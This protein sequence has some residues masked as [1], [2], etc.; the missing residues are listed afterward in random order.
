MGVRLLAAWHDSPNRFHHSESRAT[1]AQRHANESSRSS[2]EF[3][4]V[5]YPILPIYLWNQGPAMRFPSPSDINGCFVPPSVHWKQ[6][7][8][9][10]PR[11]GSPSCCGRQ[12]S[13]GVATPGLSNRYAVSISM[14][15]NCAFAI[16]SIREEVCASIQLNPLPLCS[17]DLHP[18]AGGRRCTYR[19]R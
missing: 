18:H 1:Q 4:L 13:P 2:R 6:A 14:W 10:L 3:P 17:T 12:S 7:T 15:Y 5:L 19:N 16:M 11:Q 9:N 8:C